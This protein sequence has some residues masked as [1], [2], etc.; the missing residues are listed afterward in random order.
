MPFM[1]V[2]PA[3][4][5]MLAWTILGIIAFLIWARVEHVW[6]FGSKEIHEEFLSAQRA[7]ATARP[8]VAAAQN[9]SPAQAGPWFIAAGGGPA[10]PAN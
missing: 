10:R 2:W 9:S 4:R 1:F 6:P 7:G 5:I 8:T 3:I